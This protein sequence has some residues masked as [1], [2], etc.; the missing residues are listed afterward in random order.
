[1][2]N[3]VFLLLCIKVYPNFIR[4]DFFEEER[5][6]QKRSQKEKKTT[7]ARRRESEK[8]KGEIRD[9]INTRDN[10]NTLLRRETHF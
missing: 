1:M 9:F 7:Q 6:R 2:E 4:R 3:E 10:N 5:E 8:N